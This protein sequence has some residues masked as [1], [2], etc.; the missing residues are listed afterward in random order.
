MWSC[1]AYFQSPWEAIQHLLLDCRETAKGLVM[2]GH[3]GCKELHDFK[4]WPKS[5]NL[6]S[7]VD[8]LRRLS[9]ARKRGR[10]PSMETLPS[11]KM[12]T[13]AVDESGDF[14]PDHPVFASNSY[15]MF[16][17]PTC[18][19]PDS[20]IPRVVELAADPLKA[21]LS[22]TSVWLSD[23]ANLSQLEHHAPFANTANFPLHQPYGEEF[24]LRTH[25]LAQE[26]T[27]INSAAVELDDLFSSPDTPFLD[28]SIAQTTPQSTP[29]SAGSRNTS[30]GSSLPDEQP[31]RRLSTKSSPLRPQGGIY[32]FQLPGSSDEARSIDQ[33]PTWSPS[34]LS[35]LSE[36][37]SGTPDVGA[38]FWSAQ[39][40]HH[41]HTDIAS[42][43]HHNENTAFMS[44]STAYTSNHGGAHQDSTAQS[45]S[46]ECYEHAGNISA[47]SECSYGN[48]RNVSDVSGFSLV[49]PAQ[50][51]L[52]TQMD[53]SKPEAF[54]GTA[55]STSSNYEGP[56]SFEMSS[57]DGTTTNL[58]F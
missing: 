48:A 35:S 26:P 15:G 34:S 11:G 3:Q 51:S 18:E 10:N 17:M 41:G 25:F 52:A 24:Q 32:N 23:H 16:D 20:S 21:E 49:S 57:T 9:G 58:T 6:M 29:S 19:A 7:P 46:T 40:I 43:N 4:R 30:L 14:D 47:V 39:R 54:V 50:M 42:P 38:A 45:R 22:D 5:R 28:P 53:T 12:D 1:Q 55:S 31:K 37:G 56:V 44:M 8:L 2:C 13:L 36:H 33:M 27:A